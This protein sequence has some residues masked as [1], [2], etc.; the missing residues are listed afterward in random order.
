MREETSRATGHLFVDLITEKTI[1]LRA[2]LLEYL[3]FIYKELCNLTF[4]IEI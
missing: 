3:Y 4:E 1:F 2:I